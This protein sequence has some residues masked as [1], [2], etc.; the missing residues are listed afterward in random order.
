MNDYKLMVEKFIERATDFQLEHGKLSVY[1]TNCA[2]RDVKF[3]FEQ[4]VLTVMLSG[5]KTVVS[6]KLKVEFFPGTFFIPESNTVQKVDIANASVNNPTKCL[7][8]ELNPSFLSS[9]HQE[10]NKV[11]VDNEK[12]MM[13]STVSDNYHS[14][15]QEDMNSQFGNVNQLNLKEVKQNQRASHASN[16]IYPKDP[17]IF[18]VKGTLHHQQS[19]PQFKVLSEDH[20]KKQLVM[21]Q[22]QVSAFQTKQNTII[23]KKARVLPKNLKTSDIYED[24]YKLVPKSSAQYSAPKLVQLSRHKSSTLNTSNNNVKNQQIIYQPTNTMSSSVS[25]HEVKSIKFITWMKNI[26]IST[27][28]IPRSQLCGPFL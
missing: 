17:Q 26:T 21:S 5:H 24:Q 25:Y 8:L 15:S 27:W 23:T 19:T 28:S 11:D 13:G 16:L 10:S 7:V 6:K 20:S 18:N 4:N 14:I 1:E 2:C 22:S 3:F 9:F 12:Y